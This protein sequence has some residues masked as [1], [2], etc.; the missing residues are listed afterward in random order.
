MKLAEWLVTK[1]IRQA[2]LSRML[3]VT[4]PTVHNWVNRKFPPSSKQMMRLYQM[5]NGKV[6]LKDWCEEFEVK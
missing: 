1:G 5:S 2:E 6:G 4:Q 3:N